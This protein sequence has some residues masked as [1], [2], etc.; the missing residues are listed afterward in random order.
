[1]WMQTVDWTS[2]LDV[3]FLAAALWMCLTLMRTAKTAFVLM[4]MGGI[5]VAYIAAKS[6]G[7]LLTAW[8]LL[9]LF[10]FA[11]LSVVV[12]C[13]DDVRTWLN[14]TVA[15]WFEPRGASTRETTHDTLVEALSQLAAART[16][17]LIVI[18]GKQ[19]IAPEV[20]GGVE[21]DG[22]L[23][24]P[25]VL[26]LFDSSSPGHDGALVLRGTRALRFG[27]HLPLSSNACVLQGRGTR[28]A[29]ALGLSERTDALCLVVSEERGDISSAVHGQLRRVDAG[30]LRQT[31]RRHAKGEAVGLTSPA[32]SASWRMHA[33]RAL[34]ACLLAGL[35]WT[36]AIPGSEV[37]TRVYHVP[38][39]IENLPPG[40]EVASV[41][42]ASV[43]V[44]VS[45]P[46]RKLLLTTEHD[47][48]PAID[49]T[50][51]RPGSKTFV[52]RRSEVEA[53]PELEVKRVHPHGIRVLL[54]P[55]TS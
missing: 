53:P 11:S 2:L 3:T 45:G 54:R 43:T 40:V 55:E 15:R 7:L 23:S 48:K 44:E 17:A 51:A 30:E 13:Q 41:G 32:V 21:L 12:L 35:I 6:V 1:M 14:R 47:I 36:V 52:L 29:A 38:V 18:P 4:L 33:G 22:K 34:L 46:Q 31:L 49:A 10:G 26:S 50:D 24:F 42:P 19:S 37:T 9:F 28:H 5:G 20:H 16:G 27:V 8:S 25:L 39:A